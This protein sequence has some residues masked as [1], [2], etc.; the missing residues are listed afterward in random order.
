MSV[1]EQSQYL[2]ATVQREHKTCP[3]VNPQGNTP[4]GLW[5]CAPVC[6]GQAKEQSQYLSATVQREHETCPGVN[7]QGNTP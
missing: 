3:G 5:V 7:P 4:M 2:S 1:T 6:V